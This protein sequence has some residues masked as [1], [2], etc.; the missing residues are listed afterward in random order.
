MKTTS[1]LLRMTLCAALM[2]GIS[3]AA[4]SEPAPVHRVPTGDEDVRGQE[5]GAQRPNYTTQRSESETKTDW[6][7]KP[8]NGAWTRNALNRGLQHHGHAEA[9]PSDAD[10][11]LRGSVQAPRVTPGIRITGGQPAR[12]VSGVPWPKAVPHRGSDTAIVG[13]V[14]KPNAGSTAAINGADVRRKR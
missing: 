13:G 7:E 8:G 6:R 10:A 11:T 4:R 14:A 12:P 5:T 2:V 9:W 1:I 3:S